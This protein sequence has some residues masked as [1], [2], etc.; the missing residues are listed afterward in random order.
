MDV[1][2]SILDEPMI[3]YQNYFNK[4][5][6]SEFYDKTSSRYL[7]NTEKNIKN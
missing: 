3:Y 2:L 7:I 1:T 6:Q 4:S 5:K